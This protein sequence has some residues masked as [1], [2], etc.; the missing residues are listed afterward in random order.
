MNAALAGMLLMLITA[1]M[2]GDGA[3]KQPAADPSSDLGPD[4]VMLDQVKGCYGTVRFEHLLHAKMSSMTDGCVNCH[5]DAKDHVEKTG[6]A[7][8]SRG[9]GSAL[10]GTGMEGTGLVIRP[11]RTC[12]E[13][14]SV[15]VTGDVPG[16]RGAYHRQC[17]GC[18]TEWAH[19]N[20]CGFCH[21]DSTSVKGEAERPRQLST[22]LQPHLSPRTTYVYETNF[23]PMPTVTFHHDEHTGLFGLDCKD[24]HAG[25][26]C[27]NCHGT[28]IERPIVN[29]QQSCYKCHGETRCITCHNRG[30][31]GSFDHANRSRWTLRPGH[32]SLRCQECHGSATMPGPVD[33]ETCATCHAKR[34]GD[35]CFNHSKTG[36][37]LDGDHAYFAC[38][39]CHSG[40]DDR[41]LA[42][43][44]GCHAE[45]PVMGLRRV[46]ISVLP[47]P[48][49]SPTSVAPVFPAAPAMP[50]T[51]CP[52]QGDAST[53]A[54]P[55]ATP[56]EKPA[57]TP[58]MT[59]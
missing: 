53:P 18:H 44:D 5:H 40:G 59:P 17:L 25:S 39:D 47:L 38:T 7:S 56:D 57:G 23:S 21:G 34:Y 52:G 51:E 28:K 35:E 1:P 50:I 29:R 26:S 37:E 15:I 22:M 11:C 8:V 19:E 6:E 12:H 24:C 3:T 16:L 43:C 54:T 58:T 41:M 45:R 10:A 14:N 2:A 4:V 46:G 30:V 42:Q 36:V 55:V 9:A 48:T 49:A 33:S 27:S 13:A 32:A 31:R 20:G